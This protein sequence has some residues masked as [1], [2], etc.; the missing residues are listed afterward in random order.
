M[1]LRAQSMGIKSFPPAKRLARVRP[2]EQHYI[3]DRFSIVRCVRARIR[4]T[5]RINYSIDN[6]ERGWVF[7]LFLLL[8][9]VVVVVVFSIFGSEKGQN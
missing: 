5:K 8:L 3:A 9:V 2:V 1:N 7:R 4:P 6:S